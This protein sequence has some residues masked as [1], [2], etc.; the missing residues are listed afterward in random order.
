M[1]RA[2]GAR[3]SPGPPTTL[4]TPRHIGLPL[5]ASKADLTQWVTYFDDQPDDR[6]VG[7]GYK[8]GLWIAGRNAGKPASARGIYVGA[9]AR[10]VASAKGAPIPDTGSIPADAVDFLVTQGIYAQDARDGD[11]S[12]EMALETFA[13]ASASQLVPPSAFSPITQGDTQTVDRWLTAGFPVVFCQEIDASFEDLTGT[14]V[15][16]GPKGPILG[17]H[18]MVLCGYDAAAYWAWNS[19]GRGFGNNGVG[20]IDRSWFAA[21]TFDLVAVCGSPVLA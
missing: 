18:C 10:E 19:W 1:T 13:E 8:G 20:R 16:A 2:C 11:P 3:R 17:G 4:G 15:W 7:Q 21:N 6:C 14:A 5:A 9:R 12:A